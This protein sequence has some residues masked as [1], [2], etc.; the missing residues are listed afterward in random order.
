MVFISMVSV[1]WLRIKINPD[2][3]Y[4]EIRILKGPNIE[5]AESIQYQSKLMH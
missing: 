4:W 1:V 3:F 2:L 5:T